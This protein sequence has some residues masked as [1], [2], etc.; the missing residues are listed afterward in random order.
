MFISLVGFNDTDTFLLPF[1]NW[2]VRN[3][4][5]QF[6]LKTILLISRSLDSTLF[7]T[8]VL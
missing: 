8:F 2:T 1:Y 7:V 3:V 6:W 4:Y 5:G